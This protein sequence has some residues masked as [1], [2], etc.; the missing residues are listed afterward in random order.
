MMVLGLDMSSAFYTVE[1]SVIME[2]LRDHFPSLIPFFLM[3]YGRPGRLLLQAGESWKT[4]WSSSGTRQGDP[5]SPILF[6]LAHCRAIRRTQSQHPDLLFPS[7]AD[8]T[9][10][11]RPPAEVMAACPLLV[12]PSKSVAW[13]PRGLPANLQLLHGCQTPANGLAYPQGSTRHTSSRGG[14]LAGMPSTTPRP[15]PFPSPPW[16][17]TAG[18]GHSHS[19]HRPTGMLPATD[20]RPNGHGGRALQG[21]RQLP[22]PVPGISSTF[23]IFPLRLIFPP[24]FPSYSHGRPWLP[25]VGAD[26]ASRIL[27]CWHRIASLLLMRFPSLHDPV[28]NVEEGSFSFQADLRSIRDSATGSFPSLQPLLTPFSALAQ[29]SDRGAQS[30][31]LTAVEDERRR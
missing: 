9:H 16:G 27:G 11:I 4:L 18:V 6:A 17:H 28:R 5:L 20:S 19:L 10:V 24:S 7:Y 1:R 14:E 2:E 31:L 30:R 22:S 23:F 13:S 26:G 3:A 12:C 8:D 15:P 25:V 21:M 29:A